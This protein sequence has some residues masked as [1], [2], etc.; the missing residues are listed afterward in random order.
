M[1]YVATVDSREREQAI[2][3]CASLNA[4]E[5]TYADANSLNLDST[6]KNTLSNGSSNYGTSTVHHQKKQQLI[7]ENREYLC[8][9]M[10]QRQCQRQ[11]EI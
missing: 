3:S 11:K 7:P 4:T 5:E 9:I 6:T 8:L 1:Q 2:E 10:N